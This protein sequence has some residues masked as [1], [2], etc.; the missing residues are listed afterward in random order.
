MVG[1]GGRGGAHLGWAGSEKIV[2]ISDVTGAYVNEDGID[3][4]AALEWVE[5]HDALLTEFESTGNAT[6]MDDPMK[7]LEIDVDVLV[8]AALESQITEA[9]APDVKARIIA[10]CA[11]GPVTP[12]ADALL[13]EKGVFIIPD[14]LCNAGGV[15]VSYFEWV[16]NRTAYYWREKRVLEEL[17][18]IMRHAF[19]DVLKSSL[20]HDVPMRVAAFIVGIQ[21]VT[22]TAELRGLY[23]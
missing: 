20:E 7:L 23:A 15:T 5:S 4:A 2:A 3:V 16:Q 19:R 18:A 13:N 22:R 1:C 8:P 21:R 17:D 11:N 9:N 12:E 6:K 10:E 14:I